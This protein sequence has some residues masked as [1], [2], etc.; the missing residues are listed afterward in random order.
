MLL[1]DLAKELLQILRICGKRYSTA[2]AVLRD[3]FDRFAN[4]ALLLIIH[5]SLMSHVGTE[6]FPSRNKGSL[7][8]IT[9][10]FVT[11]GVPEVGNA[12]RGSLPLIIS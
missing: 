4:D 1:R 10:S 8:T 12:A 11:D 3:P 7:E 6:K 5:A 2:D 9:K